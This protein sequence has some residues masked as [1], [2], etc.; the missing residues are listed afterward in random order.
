MIGGVRKRGQRPTLLVLMGV[1]GVGKTTT[2]QR[3][4]KKLGWEFRDA[5][6]FHPAANIAKMQSGTPLDDT[7]RWPWLDAIGN[8]IDQRLAHGGR[9]IVTCSALK[10]IYRERLLR[11]RP[12]VRLVYLKGSKALIADRL[13]RRSDHFMPQALL[14]SQFAALE[15]PRRDER[16]IV[17][18]VSQTPSQV[19]ANIMRYVEPR[20]ST[21]LPGHAPRPVKREPR[22]HR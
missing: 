18:N 8:W 16:A 2:G 21:T 7:D 13:T 17:V 1:S 15:E 10:R 6:E 4:A 3:L 12:D 20:S 11:A 22:P 19:V 14:E 9:A 5:D